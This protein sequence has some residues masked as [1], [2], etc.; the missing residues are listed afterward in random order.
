MY[1]EGAQKDIP[2]ENQRDL[3]VYILARTDLPSLNPGKLAAQVH[4]AGTQM[5]AN[6]GHHPLVQEYVQTGNAQ[7]ANGFNTTIVLG[8]CRQEIHNVML[9]A[10][11]KSMLFNSVVDPS[12][13]FWVENMEIA[14]LIPQTDMTKIIKVLDNGKVLMVREE[15]TCAWILGNRNDPEFRAL[16]DGLDLHA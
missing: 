11:F 14:N 10:E 1:Y 5:M 8:A 9:M 7:G 15:V 16:F 12:Y 6:H 2:M 3:A 13:P 4:H